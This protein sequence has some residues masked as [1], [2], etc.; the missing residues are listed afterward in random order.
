MLGV[1]KDLEL[2]RQSCSVKDINA[3]TLLVGLMM[4][5]RKKCS[6]HHL[7]IQ[8]QW[9]KDSSLL[10]LWAIDVGCRQVN[11]IHVELGNATT[12][13]GKNDRMCFPIVNK[14]ASSA[15]FS[16]AGDMAVAAD[17]VPLIVFWNLTATSVNLTNDNSLPSN[18]QTTRNEM[19]RT[20]PQKE[21]FLLQCFTKRTDAVACKFESHEHQAPTETAPC[22]QQD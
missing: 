4:T 1:A 19:R 12:L 3:S 6:Q 17:A 14:R 11:E 15:A 5:E 2:H 10:V 9:E 7:E 22:F 8:L 20:T 16:S 18:R 13:Q 21:T